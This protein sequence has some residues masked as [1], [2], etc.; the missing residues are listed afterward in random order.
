MLDSYP[1]LIARI[2]ELQN[3][4]FLSHAEWADQYEMRRALHLGA[5]QEVRIGGVR[6]VLRS[7]VE[8]VRIDVTGE[9][10][11]GKTRLVLEATRSE[12]LA[13][14]VIYYPEPE[15]FLNGTLLPSLARS[16]STL[17]G[18][19]VLDETTLETRVRV[20]DRLKGAGRRVRLITISTDAPRA[21][22]DTVLA[23]TP[24]LPDSETAAIIQ[25]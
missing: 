8:A 5:E 14:A 13:P 4:G 15:R 3:E 12:D 25:S 18:T 11:I 10:G 22:N 23:P 19:V 2:A 1:P 7:A 16:G 24:P 9:P 6:N 21:A 17:H 20:W